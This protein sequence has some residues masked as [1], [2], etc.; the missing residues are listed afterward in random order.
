M[1]R[2]EDKLADDVDVAIFMG[3]VTGRACV[4]R[5][6]ARISAASLFTAAFDG[7]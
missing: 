1:D 5:L 6:Y 2:Q 4:S 7:R 3:V